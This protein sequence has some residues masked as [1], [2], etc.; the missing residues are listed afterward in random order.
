MATK[1]KPTT[2]AETTAT[3]IADADAHDDDSSSSS[4]SSDDDDVVTTHKI[5]TKKHHH[6][7]CFTNICFR[8]IVIYCY[9]F[10]QSMNQLWL[11]LKEFVY[12]LFEKKNE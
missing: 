7:V 11:V 12:N 10:R 4:D 1:P 2:V 9:F 5:T 8:Q 6:T 3:T